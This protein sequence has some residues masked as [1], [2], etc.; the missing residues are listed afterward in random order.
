MLSLSLS[1]Y[2]ICLENSGEDS[3]VAEKAP[4]EWHIRNVFPTEKSFGFN[5]ESLA[6]R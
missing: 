6:F 1:I 5:E 4:S 3:S 2:E